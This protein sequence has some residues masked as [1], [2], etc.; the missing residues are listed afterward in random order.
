M[1]WQKYPLS[2][3]PSLCFWI[4]LCLSLLLTLFGHKSLFKE[5]SVISAWYSLSPLDLFCFQDKTSKQE[6]DLAHH[7]EHFCSHRTFVVREKYLLCR[8]AF[9]NRSTAAILS[10]L[11][12]YPCVID[13][14]F[15][16]LCFL[17]LE[18][19]LAYAVGMLYHRPQS[20]ASV[21]PGAG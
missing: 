13:V 2:F 20:T 21:Y 19:F 12:G 16:K 11:M 10:L 1:V 3:H 17:A 14:P 8:K 7:L 9:K 5:S 4:F 6:L 15:R 18:L